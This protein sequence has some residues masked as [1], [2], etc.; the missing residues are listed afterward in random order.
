M[1]SIVSSII[2]MCICHTAYSQT[3]TNATV[4]A[5][6]GTGALHPDFTVDWNIGESTVTDSYA[7]VNTFSNITLT[8]YLYVTCGVLQP[9]DYSRLFTNG[10]VANT[11]NWTA[12]D[13]GLFPVPT[14]DK[15][16]IDFKSYTAGKITV[17]LLDNTGLILKKKT[18]TNLSAAYKQNWD[19]SMYKTGIYFFQ[20]LLQGM[21][22]LTIIKSGAFQIIKL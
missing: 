19:L 4:N 7:G 10:S 12:D 11:T 1:R 6:G 3:N 21:D 22:D 20:I 16:T 15:L 2:I 5:G 13:V 9:F 14:K 8:N 17:F 18:V